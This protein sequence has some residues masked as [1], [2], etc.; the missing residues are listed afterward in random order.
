[1]IAQASIVLNG[2]VVDSDDI[3]TTYTVC[4]SHLQSQA[5]SNGGAGGKKL[6]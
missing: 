4:S 3:S 5:E 1:M 6:I 2:A